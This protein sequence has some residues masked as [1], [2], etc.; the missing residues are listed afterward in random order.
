MIGRLPFAPC[1]I[2][3]MDCSSK[4]V[5]AVCVAES[6][7]ASFTEISNQHLCVWFSPNEMM[8]LRLACSPFSWCII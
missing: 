1:L 3:L 2:T 7:A 6:C 5:S 8:D 4:C